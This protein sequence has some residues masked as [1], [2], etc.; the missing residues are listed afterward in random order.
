M[1]PPQLPGDTP[2]TDIFQPVEID[3]VKPFWHKLKIAGFQRFDGRLRQLLHFYKPLLLYHG[4]YGGPAAVMG[5]Y[6][7]NMLFHFHQKTLFLQFPDDQLPG[8][9]RCV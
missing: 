6:I 7:M 5:S 4:F 9:I 8:L 1:S 3:L 2:V